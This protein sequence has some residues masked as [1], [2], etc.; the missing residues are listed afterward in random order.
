MSRARAIG[1]WA[2]LAAGC[3]GAPSATDSSEVREPPR[4]AKV[5]A[6]ARS[7][8]LAEPPAGAQA[9]TASATKTID[10]IQNTSELDGAARASSPKDVDQDD[11]AKSPAAPPKARI[12]SI[13]YTTWIFG[14]PKVDTRFIGYIR[15]GE[16][17]GL[18]SAERVRGEGCS[19]GFYLIEPRGFVCADRTVTESPD[20]RFIEAIEATRAVAGPFP[21]RY[22]ISGGAPMYNRVPIPA[23]QTK[24][25]RP[26]G[27]AG[28]WIPLI[29]SLSAHEDLAEPLRIEPTDPLPSFL[30]GGRPVTD[31][32]IGLVREKIPHGSMLS[33]TRAFEAEGRTWLLAADL[34]L[35]PADRVRPFRPSAFRGTH[36]SGEVKLPL[37]WMRKTAKPKYRMTEAGE[38]EALALT[39]PVRSF[40]GLSGLSVEHKG[41]MYLET[42][43]REGGRP[44]F[45]AADDATVMAPAKKRPAGV[46]PGQ[47][48]VHVRITQGTLVAYED[49]KPV[50]ATLMS[51]G[52]GG[53]PVKGH[54]PV[55][56]STTPTGTYYMTF[57]DRAATMSPDKP[58]EERTLWIA[59]VPHTQY[60]NPPFAIHAAYWHERFGEPTSAGCVNVSPLDAEALFH[61][62]DP[63]VPEGWQGATGAGAPINGPT[64]AVVVSR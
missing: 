11:A 27:P 7:D 18:R 33:F 39:W 63:K 48:W 52:S 17:I 55:K 61:W 53:V 20:A 15:V 3:A 23:E 60:F 43:E 13:G 25:E 59:D 58:G 12:T 16:S 44:F 2:T 56:M 45:I 62:S 54:D 6:G 4:E 14:R 24:A 5:A 49:L 40:V 35:V 28:K 37:A 34:S 42:T 50:F 38:L 47:K 31:S 1:L 9:K 8:G 36:L 10:N 22:A 51:P 57:K 21:Y 29:K 30:A 19:G 46:L 41:E 26:F 64:T 32:R